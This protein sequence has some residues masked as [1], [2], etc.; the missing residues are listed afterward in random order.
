MN[1][2]AVFYGLL[3]GF[4]G[5]LLGSYIF[6]TLFTEYTFYTGVQIIKMQGSLGKLITL[7]S[8]PNLIIFAILLKM[9]K[10]II[11]RGIIL[12]LLIMTLIT[13]LI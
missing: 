8:I 13:V 2:L 10:D 7:G 3:L 12:S 11:A 5:T 1:K 9:N 4:A 6:V